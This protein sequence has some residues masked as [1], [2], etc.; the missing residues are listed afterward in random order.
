MSIWPFASTIATLMK[1][2]NK[3]GIRHAINTSAIKLAIS[4]FHGFGEIFR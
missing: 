4:A 3:N 1:E 2:S